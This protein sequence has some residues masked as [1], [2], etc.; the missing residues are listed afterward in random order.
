MADEATQVCNLS[1]HSVTV[2]TGVNDDVMHDNGDSVSLSDK[3]KVNEVNDDDS[4][5]SRSRNNL[6]DEQKA[7][8]T[9][10]TRWKMAKEGKGG[11]VVSNELL[12]HQDKVEG[13]P[14][15]QLCLLPSRRAE[16]M[17]LAH[18]SVFGRHMGDGSVRKVHANKVRRLVARCGVI[19]D[20]DVEFGRVLT[21]V[22]VVTSVLPSRRVDQDKLAHLDVS[23]RVQLCQ[24]LDEFADCFVDKPGLCDVVTHQIQTTPEDVPRQVCPCR[25]PAVS[26]GEVDRQIA[27]LLSIR[28]IRRSETD[29]PITI[30]VAD[31]DGSVCTACDCCCR[32]FFTERSSNV[33]ADGGLGPL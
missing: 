14:M 13:Q 27:E 8:V 15:S 9:L 30:P 32:N 31:K 21:H 11:F 4:L 26:K 10:A 20:K 6:C 1:E 24:L 29:S 28:L 12:Y 3:V 25:V 19:A 33:V 5:S 23:E 2:T 18:D 7:D 22:P 17:K 16:V